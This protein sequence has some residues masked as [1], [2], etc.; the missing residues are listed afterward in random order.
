MINAESASVDLRHLR[1][2]VAIVDASGFARAAARLNLSQPALSRQIHALERDLGVKLF[3]RTRRRVQLTSE[4]EDLLARSRRLLTDAHALGERARALTGG[5]T[6]V[7]RIGAA[8]QAIET[9]LAAFCSRYRRRHPGVDINLTEE[10]GANL[11]GRLE[12]GDVHLALIAVGDARFHYRLLAPLYVLAIAPSAHPLAR[13]AVVEMTELADTPLLVP[14]RGFGSREWFDAACAVAD[15]RPRVLMESGAPQTLVALARA[16]YGIAIVPSNTPVPRGGVRAV[17]IL[18]AGV[19]VGRWVTVAWDAR[20]SLPPYA[21]R[22][23]SEFVARTR[24]T[25][26]GRDLTRRAPPLPR[27]NVP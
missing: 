7:L 1:A 10:G 22:F 23:V 2:F 13:R 14:R 27:P 25:H 6:G 26:P 11:P 24:S 19:P 5:E 17:P 21:E 3:D 8:P 12:R 20:R 4:G 18:L 9:M 15:M 16:G